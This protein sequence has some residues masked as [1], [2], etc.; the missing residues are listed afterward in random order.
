MLIQF[1]E[2]SKVYQMGE[3]EVHALDRINLAIQAGEFVAIVGASGS[4]KTTL[5]DILGCLSRPTSG[6]YLLKG[7]PV[8]RL[9]D[10]E[11]ARVRNE[12]IGFIFQTFHLLGRQTAV[13]NVALPLFYAG[14]PKEER[15]Q[16]A[17]EAL[18]R[19]GL[20]DR[21]HHRPNQLSGGQQQRVAIARA[22]VNNPDIILADEPTGNLDSKSGREIFDL[23]AQLQKQGHT[24]ILVTHDP[25]LAGRTE[26]TLTIRDGQIISDVRTAVKSQ[27]GVP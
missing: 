12:K 6:D 22:L 2:I 11:L 27:G 7:E 14:A 17:Q 24:L 25:E 8:Q 9:S 1:K 5:L 21:M 19:V 23:L 4:G 18:A 20:S 16:R 15:M 26:R 10:A 13:A 3:V